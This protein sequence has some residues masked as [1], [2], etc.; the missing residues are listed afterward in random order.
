MN[1]FKRALL[2]VSR[3]KS[4]SLI[5]FIVIFILGNVIAGAYSIFRST[6]NVEKQIKQRLGSTSTILIDDEKIN[7]WWIDNPNS[8][9]E[10]TPLKLADINLVGELPYVKFYDYQLD[11]YLSSRNFVTLDD[12]SDGIGIPEMPTSRESDEIIDDEYLP[13]FT[14]RGVYY[15]NIRDIEESKIE[16]TSGNVF[17]QQD[18]DSS[19]RKMVISEELARANGVSIGDRVLFVQQM[20]IWDDITGEQ[21]NRGDLEYEFEII[22][23]FKALAFESDNDDANDATEPGIPSEPDYQLNEL[24]NRIYIPASVAADTY[25]D[26][27]TMYL[28]EGLI[29]PSEIGSG[30]IDEIIYSGVTPFYFLNSVDDV[31]NFRQDATALIPD[32]YKIQVSSDTYESI[33]GSMTSM[34]NMALMTLVIAIAASILILSLVIILFLRDRKHELGIYLSLGEKRSRI[35]SQIILEVLLVALLGMG[36]SVFSGNIIASSLSDNL[37]AQQ[38][39][40]DDWWDG[41]WV[42]DPFETGVT[43]E[44]VKDA[45]EVKLT[46]SY[47]AVFMLVGL[48][49]S[50]A[51]TLA[52]MIYITRLEPK[53]IMM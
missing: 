4:K 35:F 31:E 14:M 53:K 2:S 19:L 36:L 52:P 29:D 42:Y 18:I 41:G 51:S 5:L 43:E 47:V 11:A 21:I 16:L 28:E 22:G 30:G 49:V 46:V 40:P 33:S 15:P 34:Q 24:N 13:S 9:I 10:I 39:N 44:D 12:F 48:G 26:L 8:E 27:Y 6:E 17:T 38:E 25:H 32:F 7:Q 50:T 37:L 3:R 20:L 1:I 23:L 45:Y